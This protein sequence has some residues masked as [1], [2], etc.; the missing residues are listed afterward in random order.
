MLYHKR[1]KRKQNDIQ[2]VI[3]RTIAQ[4]GVVVLGKVAPSASKLFGASLGSSRKSNPRYD[5]SRGARR[6]IE[7]GYIQIEK[8]KGEEVLSLTVKGEQALSRIKYGMIVMK[9]PARWDGKWRVVIYDIKED[10][11]RMRRELREALV[12]FDFVPI[13]KSV[14]VYP[15][16]CESLLATIKADFKI[17]REVLYMVVDKLE[18]DKW[19]RQHFGI[20]E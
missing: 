1:G 2:G 16:P 8:R 10:R 19:L 4:M 15:Y 11:T 17:G 13:Q 12:Y 14:W 18:N 9:K 3:L 20:K 5:I 6:L 7:K